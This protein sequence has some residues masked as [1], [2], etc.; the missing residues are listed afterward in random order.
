MILNKYTIYDTA[1]EAY[2]QDYTLE[3]DLI[4]IREFTQMV[5]SETKIAQNPEDYSLWRIGT[6]DN[7]T[8]QLTPEEPNCIAKAHERVILTE[9]K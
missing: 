3:T 5:N 7:Q 1:L 2:H 9:T 6:F 8:G 4:A